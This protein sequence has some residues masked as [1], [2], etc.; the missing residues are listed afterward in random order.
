MRPPLHHARR[1]GLTLTAL[2]LLAS[3]IARAD[4]DLSKQPARPAPTWLRDGCS[5]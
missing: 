4:G 5:V 3:P 1:I 2:L